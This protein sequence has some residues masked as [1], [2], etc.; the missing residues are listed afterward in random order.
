MLCIQY[1]KAIYSLF[2]T[3]GEVPSMS[4]LSKNDERSEEMIGCN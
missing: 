3:H 4:R 2:L 1:T